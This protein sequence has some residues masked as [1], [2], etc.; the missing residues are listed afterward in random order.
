MKLLKNGQTCR[1]GEWLKNLSPSDR[2]AFS[3]KGGLAVSKDKAHMSALGKKGGA[4]TSA[5]RAHMARIGKMGGEAAHA[6]RRRRCSECGAF[7]C[8]ECLREQRKY[9]ERE[10]E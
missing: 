8:T 4:V 6:N 10:S 7:D 3:R 2:S 9:R 1:Q 5:N